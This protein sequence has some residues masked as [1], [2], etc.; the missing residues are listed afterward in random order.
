MNHG[1]LSVLLGAFT[2]IAIFTCFRASIQAPSQLSPQGCRMSYMSPSYILQ[3]GFNAAWT[4]F[5][6]RY[7]LWLYREVGWENNQPSG[8][9]VLFIPGNAG[10]SHQVRSIAS[11]ATRQYFSSPYI[12]SPD[13]SSRSPVTKPLD[14]FAVEFNEDLSAFHGPTLLSERTYA[15]DAIRYILSL[16]P[17]NTSIVVMGH[18]M[19]GVVATSLL[20]SPDI[21]AIITMS[22]PHTL[23]PARF[24]NRIEGIYSNNHQHLVADPTPIVSICGGA[25][26][27]MVP[28][29]SCILPQPSAQNV[30]RKTIFS[31][32]MERCWT[33]IGHREMVW[34][35]QARWQVARAALELSATVPST[36]L[37][38]ARILDTWLR[39]GHEDPPITDISVP[40]AD[41]A[42]TEAIPG[43][44]DTSSG[45]TLKLV[46]PVFRG[47][48][49]FYLRPPTV[50]ENGG[51]DGGQR[52]FLLYLAGGA[53]GTV[54]PFSSGS[55]RAS[56]FRCS[57]AEE[58]STERCVPIPPTALYLLPVTHPHQEFPVSGAGSD[59]TEGIALFDGKIPANSADSWVAIKVDGANGGGWVIG[60]FTDDSYLVRSDASTF[61]VLF[62]SATVSLPT[63]PSGNVPLKTEITFPN[64]LVNVLLV[65]RLTPKFASH[66]CKDTLLPP[67]LAHKTP[68]ESHYHRIHPSTSP[69]YRPI[70]LHSHSSAP[71]IHTSFPDRGLNLT[72]HTSGEPET[73]YPESIAIT[74]D[75]WMSIG[76]WGYRYWPVL[77]TW[78]IG[79]ASLVIWQGLRAAVYETG[80]PL[81]PLSQAIPTF[82]KSLLPRLILISFLVAVL[83]LPTSAYLGLSG[84][85]LLAFLAPILVL[86]STGLVITTFWLLSLLAYLAAV[87]SSAVGRIIRGKDCEREPPMRTRRLRTTIGSI[88]IVFLLIFFFVPWQVAFLGSYLIIFHTTVSSA[89]SLPTWR[90]TSHKSKT[91]SLNAYP[92]SP[93]SPPLPPR[94]SS[95]ARA[96]KKLNNQ[97][98]NHT[99]L[100]YLLLLGTLLLPL[101]APVLAVWVRTLST[102]G[103][104]T[105]F[106]GDHNFLYVAPWLLLADWAWTCTRKQGSIRIFETESVIQKTA[107][108]WPF[109]MVAFIAFVYGPRFTYLISNFTSVGLGIAFCTCVGRR[110]WRVE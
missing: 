102:A 47:S 96:E 54:S 36:P 95:H 86:L 43:T 46:N 84:E 70:L 92:P 78:S 39:N 88:S 98:Y 69:P 71:Y 51:S 91:S 27:M 45:P 103:Y 33:G 32:G 52:S 17:P 60:G 77:A 14:I 1:I 93:A 100:A 79:I 6:G 104:A 29:E 85:P 34:C 66:S 61:A 42:Q 107:V 38:R 28:S 30:F 18:S 59:E 11:S 99:L 63:P 109:V 7:S 4:S 13:F 64:V 76:R 49:V 81:P 24:D 58:F 31:S 35:H 8:M 56:V 16:Y 110:Y 74:I 57:S 97:I 73:C 22:T 75:W 82:I 55:L 53:I 20:P 67:L 94:L 40:F 80:V 106:N 9:P 48:R 72:L 26:D 62:G 41:G 83:P 87:I 21:S 10:S 105:P 5:S 3:S 90:R 25:T 89:C 44:K 37:A 23:P 65:Y 19:G 101:S 15:L 2:A 12:I 50:A 108:T 68:A